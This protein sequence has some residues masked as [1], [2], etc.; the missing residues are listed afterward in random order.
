VRATPPA[1]EPERAR[2]LLDIEQSQGIAWCS[3]H[4][5]SCN[6][7]HGTG[8]VRRL[9]VWSIGSRFRR[10][11]G[12]SPSSAEPPSRV[13]H[14]LGHDF[15]EF[16]LEA[17]GP[18]AR[19]AEAFEHAATVRNLDGQAA[20]APVDLGDRRRCRRAVTTAHSSS[21]GGGFDVH[22]QSLVVELAAI[23]KAD[24]LFRL[25]LREEQ[26][27]PVAAVALHDVVDHAREVDGALTGT[28]EGDAS[29]HARGHDVGDTACQAAQVIATLEAKQHASVQSSRRKPKPPDASAGRTI[30]GQLHQAHVVEKVGRRSCR[31][32]DELGP[33]A[34]ADGLENAREDASYMLL[35]ARWSAVERSH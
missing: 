8:G 26:G 6:P 29:A 32:D 21:Q 33:V 15:V 19:D 11:S 18:W 24:R 28:S 31:H 34:A 16:A 14:A 12:K 10:R 17:R 2:Q 13:T 7:R 20:A 25:R 30:G 4:R 35:P 22:L 5:S 1:R 3:R 23:Q 9:P 27:R